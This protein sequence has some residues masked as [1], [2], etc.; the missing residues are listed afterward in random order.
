MSFERPLALALLAAVPILLLLESLARRPRRVVVP[1]LVVFRELPATDVDAARSRER[2]RRLLALLEGAAIV[3]A[4]FAAAGPRLGD[5]VEVAPVPALAVLVDRSASMG[6][7]LGPEP[8]APTVLDDELDRAREAIASLPVDARVVL[9]VE[10][11]LDG[12]DAPE[13]AALSRDAALAALVAIGDLGPVAAADVLRDRAATRLAARRTLVVTDRDRGEPLPN[14][15]ITGVVGAPGGQSD[16]LFVRIGN[17]ADVAADATVSVRAGSIAE[18]QAALTDPDHGALPVVASARL[19]L[20]GASERAAIVVAPALATAEA[21]L[22]TVEASSGDD[23]LAADDRVAL[24]RAPARTLR[25]VIVG[26]PAPALRRALAAAAAGLGI[27]L[28]V[29]E[30]TT[31][32]TGPPADLVVLHGVDLVAVAVPD[33]EVVIDI[34]SADADAPVGT[35]VATSAEA[36][37]SV[38]LGAV[39]V[40]RAARRAPDGL[41]PLLRDETRVLVG[42]RAGSGGRG[43]YV[44]VGFPVEDPLASDW[45]LDPSFPV[46]VAGCL[47]RAARAGGGAAGGRGGRLGAGPTGRPIAAVAAEALGVASI[48]PG[49]VTVSLADGR[50][51]SGDA[52]RAPALLPGM[53]VAEASDGRIGHAALALLSARETLPATA[54]RVRI[55]DPESDAPPRP[56]RTPP[57]G[58]LVIVLLVI[59]AGIV[60]M[61]TAIRLHLS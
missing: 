55:A 59:A 30:D 9:I 40:R 33:A 31:A 2:R 23:R 7:R 32:A 18:V 58:A 36:L 19:E 3:A 5:P 4:A 43:L 57:D 37:P 44:Y 35:L 26:E 54:P 16:A 50:R 12:D 48:D 34:R 14:V 27:A 60:I 1:S 20:P 15:G 49:S 45:P 29:A 10:P 51:M 22:V 39:A 53:I 47:D 8:A 21:A 61:A 46:L 11:A 56:S 24:V 42:A 38:D 13:P 28:A 41:A 25:A 52:L 17:A 6:R